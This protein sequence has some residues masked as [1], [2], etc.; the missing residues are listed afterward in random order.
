MACEYDDESGPPSATSGSIA[1][2]VGVTN[3]AGGGASLNTLA[4][5]ADSTQEGERKRK[6]KPNGP[7]SGSAGGRKKSEDDELSRTNLV[8]RIRKSHPSRHLQVSTCD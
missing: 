3:G 8:K 1:G 5:D 7:G 6:R 4:D 2:G